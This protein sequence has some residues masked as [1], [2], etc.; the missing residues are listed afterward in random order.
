MT[1][2]VVYF[3]IDS[4][5]PLMVAVDVSEAQLLDSSYNPPNTIRY[6]IENT[7]DCTDLIKYAATQLG[8]TIPEPEA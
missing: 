5:M 2:A 4:N 7:E 8:I 3:G 1:R 6:I